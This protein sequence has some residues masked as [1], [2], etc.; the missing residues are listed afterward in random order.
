MKNADKPKVVVNITG[1]NNKVFLGG[2][3]SHPFAIAASILVAA[4]VLA[5]SLCC[6]ELLADFVR[7]IVST[8]FGN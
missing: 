2:K 1:D 5:V 8:A 3:R 7:L 6:P 4:A